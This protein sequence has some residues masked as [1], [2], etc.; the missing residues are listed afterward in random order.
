MNNKVKFMGLALSSL[1]LFTACDSTKNANDPQSNEASEG[2]KNVVTFAKDVDIISLDTSRASDGFS[3]EMIETFTDGLVDYDKSGNIVPRIAT[4]WKKNDKGTVYTFNLRKDAKWSNGDPVTAKDFVYAWRRAVDPAT[5]S[6]YAGSVVDSGI[7]NAAAVNAGKLPLEQLGVK[8]LDDYTLEV[9]L[10]TAVPFFIKFLPIPI[11]NP[12]NEKFVTAQS[13]KYAETP[14]NLLS[15]GPFIFSE[16]N[17]LNSWKIV[18]NPNYYDA[19]DIK[20]DEI[21]FVKRQDY[22]VAALEFEKGDLDATKISSE[23]VSRYATNKAYTNVLSGYVWYLSPNNQFESL[24]NKNLRLALG[25]AIDREHIANDILKDGSVAA[26]Y[27]VPKGLATDADGKDF[28]DTS[29]RFQTY[30]VDKAKEY[31]AL[32]KKELGVDQ[33]SLQLLIEDSNE[34]KR[35]AESIQADLQALDG[36]SIELV[37]VTK[38][39]RLKRMKAGDYQLGLTRWGPNYGDPYDYLGTLFQS[40]SSFNYPKYNSPA[41]DEI[42]KKTA[43]GGAFTNDEA[44]RWSSFKEAEKLL[45]GDDGG[46]LPVY[47]AGEALLINPKVKGVEYFVVGGLIS[48]RN[49]SIQNN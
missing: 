4:D 30:N 3:L 29:P 23:L 17:K 32:A 9:T 24:K 37:T 34:V 33:I 45:L 7:K 16:W 5:A 2:H 26:D 43:P 1:L 49:I 21:D 31:L 15:N 12:L 42:V 25:Y 11:F 6:E 19:K 41:Y 20:V 8:A 27:I 36:I 13:D 18:K 22:S 38:A 10:E 47:Q 40:K 14:Q 28:R 46:A 39:E 48:Y 44:G 35:T